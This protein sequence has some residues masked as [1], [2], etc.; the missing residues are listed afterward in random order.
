[1]VVTNT[2]LKTELVRKWPFSSVKHKV[3]T[4]WQSWWE[5]VCRPALHC[6]TLPRNS[7]VLWCAAQLHEAAVVSVVMWQLTLSGQNGISVQFWVSL[8]TA[9]LD[10][11][12]CVWRAHKRLVFERKTYLTSFMSYIKYLWWNVWRVF[13]GTPCKEFL[14]P[15]F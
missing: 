15:C 12:W 11:P 10:F 2:V 7:F 6:L 1:M 5:R 14:G 8:V 9:Q 3:W 4:W 13:E